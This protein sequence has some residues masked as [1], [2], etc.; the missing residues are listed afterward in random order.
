MTGERGYLT[1]ADIARMAECSERTVSRALAAGEIKAKR[2]E[3]GRIQSQR[4]ARR[5]GGAQMIWK[6]DPA[7]GR[8]WAAN[9][10]PRGE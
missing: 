10:R 1:P 5:G 7:A 6:I 9:Y 3:A 8:E 4:G 2:V